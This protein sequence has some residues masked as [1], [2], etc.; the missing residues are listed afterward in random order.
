MKVCD[1]YCEIENGLDM[2]GEILSIDVIK[3]NHKTVSMNIKAKRPN[4]FANKEG[5]FVEPIWI[6]QKE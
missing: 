5:F 3:S 2:S 4:S 1:L 6:W